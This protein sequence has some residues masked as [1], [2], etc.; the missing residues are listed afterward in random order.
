MLA[1]A[2]SETSADNKNGPQP[3][4]PEKVFSKSTFTY[5]SVILLFI[6]TL[7]S[8]NHKDIGTLYFIFGA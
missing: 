8:P 4:S 6:E 3:N 7:F 1:I 2:A 5:S